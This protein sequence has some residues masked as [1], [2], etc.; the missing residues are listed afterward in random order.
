MDGTVANR[1]CFLFALL[2]VALAAITGCA[3]SPMEVSNRFHAE[4][5][6]GV[7]FAADG[8]GG[9]AATSDAL[10]QAVEEAGLPLGVEGVEWSHG[11][12]RVVSDQIDLSYARAQGR[13]LAARLTAFHGE[14]GGREVFL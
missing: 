6:R 9:F 2:P 7:I 8:A 5:L 13:Q 10:R 1:L 3:T 12:G 11:Y 4:N 14:C